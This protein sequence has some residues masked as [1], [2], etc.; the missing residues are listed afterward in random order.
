[1]QA[2]PYVPSYV[3]LQTSVRDKPDTPSCLIFQDDIRF[4]RI[5]TKRHEMMLSPGTSLL[6]MSHESH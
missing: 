2:I 1:M 5:R 4:M 6:P 3:S